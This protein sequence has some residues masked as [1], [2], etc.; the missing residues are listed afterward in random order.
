MAS[1]KGTGRFFTRFLCWVEVYHDLDHLDMLYRGIGAYC[2]LYL[3]QN[4]IVV[5]VF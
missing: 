2:S 3:H 5:S 4:H 1:I